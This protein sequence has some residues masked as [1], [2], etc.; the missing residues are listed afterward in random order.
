MQKELSPET[1]VGDAPECLLIISIHTHIRWSY[2]F[3]TRT[4]QHALLTSQTLGDLY[5]SI[6]CTSNE[7]PEEI[8][9]EDGQLIGYRDDGKYVSSGCV[10][11]I[12]GVAYGDGQSEEDYS[13]SVSICSHHRPLANA[14]TQEAPSADLIASRESAVR[15]KE[16]L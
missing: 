15:D 2:S 11:C 1:V 9:D 8:L 5:E 4:S 14:A 16:G 10:I 7:M 12:E 3:T 6:P 13:E